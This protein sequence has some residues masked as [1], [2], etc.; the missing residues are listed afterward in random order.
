MVLLGSRIAAVHGMKVS[1]GG[2][3]GV[4]AVLADDILDTGDTME[5]EATRFGDVVVVVVFGRRKA[6]GKIS[7]MPMVKEVVCG[8]MLSDG[9]EWVQF[10]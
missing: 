6:V 7:R 8:R 5:L 9:D 4:P 1:V 2:D 10:P 3:C